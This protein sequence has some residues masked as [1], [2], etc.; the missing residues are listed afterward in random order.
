M[1]VPKGMSKE[2]AVLIPEV[3]LTAYHLLKFDLGVQSSE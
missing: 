1:I 2:D 3:W